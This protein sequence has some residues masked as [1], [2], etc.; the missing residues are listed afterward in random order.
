MVAVNR[1]Q[2]L[3]SSG[4]AEIV[5]PLRAVKR[6]PA[7]SVAP[8]GRGRGAHTAQS[9]GSKRV[10]GIHA[11]VFRRSSLKNAA[12]CKAATSADENGSV[13][14]SE[15]RAVFPKSV[16]SAGSGLNRR[17][18]RY[19]TTTVAEMVVPGSAGRA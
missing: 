6:Q 17:D 9:R 7:L 13:A 15:N 14:P 3:P 11:C 16:A 18:D 2:P 12:R 5:T 4:A 19:G 1:T 10:A 8:A